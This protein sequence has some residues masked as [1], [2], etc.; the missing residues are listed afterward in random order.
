MHIQQITK[1]Q[2]PKHY[3]EEYQLAHRGHRS[4][5]A[6]VEGVKAWSLLLEA[7]F[8][9]EMLIKKKKISNIMY[10][11]KVAKHVNYITILSTK[12]KKCNS[13]TK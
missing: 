10:Q 7:H 8:Q 4:Q 9:T 12:Q 1:F 11:E 3:Q 2:L 6:L 5:P 13:R